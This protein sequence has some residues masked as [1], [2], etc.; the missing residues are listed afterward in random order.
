MLLYYILKKK[1]KALLEFKQK[2]YIKRLIQKKIAVQNLKNLKIKRLFF[3]CFNCKISLVRNDLLKS[4]KFFIVFK[5]II[6]H[7]KLKLNRKL[8][9]DIFGFIKKSFLLKNAALKNIQQKK[10][11][12][13]IINIKLTNT[14]TLINITD[15]K[16]NLKLLLTTGLSQLSGKQKTRQPTAILHLLR[17][18]NSKIKYLQG[19]PV[20]L[21]FTDVRIYLQTLLIRRLK[22]YFFIN[23]I[24]SYNLVAH[25]G[26]RLP[27]IKRK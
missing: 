5:K 2:I 12:V 13:L 14:N 10:F 7:N 16:G 4:K 8:F 20:A 26:C 25:N 21:H 1:R 11:V 19:H 23:T 27:K 6:S 3:L 15:T 24:R 18:L 22:K 17:Q 9:N